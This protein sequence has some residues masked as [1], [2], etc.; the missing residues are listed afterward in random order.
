MKIPSAY[1]KRAGEWRK[2]LAWLKLA[3]KNG[4]ETVLTGGE[5]KPVKIKKMEKETKA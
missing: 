1:H 5:T 4:Q 3:W 2:T